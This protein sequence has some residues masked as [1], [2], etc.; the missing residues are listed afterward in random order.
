[1]A[2]RRTDAA[3]REGLPLQILKRFDGAILGGNEMALKFSVFLT[4]DD[5]AGTLRLFRSLDGSQATIP[6]HLQAIGG[7]SFYRGCIID[8]R[9][10]LYGHTYFFC[11][12]IG[13]GLI[14]SQHLLR[15]FIGN[16]GD[17][18]LL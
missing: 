15:V 2:G 14:Y 12:I 11:E 6:H 7:Q 17:S 18:Q 10:K 5:T 4:H 8:Y 13:E 3:E 9:R 16:S 1:M